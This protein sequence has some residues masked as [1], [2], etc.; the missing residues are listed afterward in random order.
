MAGVLPFLVRRFLAGLLVLLIA[1]V[2]V[3][4][5]TRYAPG[6]P[7]T[8]RTGGK[9]SAE[10]VARLRH[11]LHLDEPVP[12]QYGRY[13]WN[14]LH[15]DL[16]EST[17][18]VGVPVGDIVFP[19]MKISLEE[20]LYPFILTFLFGVPLGIYL[21]IKRGTWQDP[22]I[23]A[24]L[25]ILSAVPVVV[26]IPFLQVLFALKLRWLPV[27][28]WHGI[29]SKNIILPTIVLT[30][31]GIVGIARLTRISLLQV[32]GDD[33]VRTARAKG[34]DERVIMWRHVFRNGFLPILTSIVYS[35]F[36]LVVGSLF[37]ER[38]FGIPG[39][40]AE[41]LDT[42]NSRD[43]DEVMALMLFGSVLFIAANIVLD[44]LYSIVDPRIRL[45]TS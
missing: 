3:F 10:T 24:L 31:G 4:W 14:L 34:L 26:A 15:G 36:G 38:L 42:I 35:L 45:G 37:V 20:N 25:L 32:L 8:V 19:K 29:F 6:D 17:R 43:Y 2:L 13:M 16:G 1:S 5:L 12:E 21:A 27:S 40:A 22:T 18:H 11:Q 39:I 7:I 23:T 33:Y 30:Y 44:I 9:A 28:G 41:T